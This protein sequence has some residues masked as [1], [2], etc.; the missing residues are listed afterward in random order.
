MFKRIGLMLAL[1]TLV[2]CTPVL[3]RRLMDEGAR[4]FDPAHLIETPEVF[5]DHLFIFGGV[6]VDTKLTATGSQIEGVFVP[7]DRYGYLQDPSHYR[8][9]FIAIYPRT[10]G[11]LD[12]MIYK[13]GREIT[14]AA[15][16]VEVRKGKI[17]EMEYSYPV[18]EVRQ[19]YLWDQYVN[20]PYYYAPYY[21]YYYGYPYYYD[22][23]G[24]WVRPYP[25]YWR[26]PW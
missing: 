13:K 10:K 21:P 22:P 19:A 5:K 9:R 15:D 14:L 2:A 7:V 6:I 3:D 24:P 25:Y 1:M 17:D 12:P 4:E 18:F 20:Y 8:G 26:G 16:F 11:L 23:W